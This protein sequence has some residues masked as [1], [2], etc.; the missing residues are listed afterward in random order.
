MDRRD[1]PVFGGGWNP[2]RELARI[3]SELNKLFGEVVPMAKQMPA[4]LQVW[5]PRVDMYDDG[6]NIIIEAEIPGAKKEDIEV[7]IKDNAVVIRGQ[8]KREEEKQDKNF[9]RTERFYGQFERVIPLPVE[10]KT[11]EAKAEMKDGILRLILPKATSEK[12]I[13]INIE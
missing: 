4:E 5:A 9:Y 10:V 6:N 8:V 13:K 1:L 11:D 3:E 2:F 12:E 7:S